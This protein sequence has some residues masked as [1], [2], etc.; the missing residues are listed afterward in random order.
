MNNLLLKQ[1]NSQ[2]GISYDGQRTPKSLKALLLNEKQI[3]FT[4]RS[5]SSNNF[6]KELDLEQKFAK[7]YNNKTFGLKCQRTDQNQ[8]R[9]S[10]C[11]W[12]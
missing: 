11:Q 9:N 4:G 8:E 5:F 2:P 10:Y 7:V 3:S 6:N 12:Q 1:N